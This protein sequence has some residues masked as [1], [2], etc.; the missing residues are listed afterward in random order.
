M[1]PEV[2]ARRH[3]KCLEIA[4]FEIACFEIAL[5]S[6]VMRVRII[7]R[8]GAGFLFF[9]W[10]VPGATLRFIGG[11]P[12][13]VRGTR[14]FARTPAVVHPD[15][16]FKVP[17]VLLVALSLF[18]FFTA[19]AGASPDN[20]SPPTLTLTEL[21]EKYSL[22]NS[23]YLQADGMDLHYVDEGS[24]SAIVLL[25]ASYQSLRT[26]DQLAER[27][28][29]NYRVVRVDFPNA[30]LSAD[31]KP[32]PPEK[33]NMMDRYQDAVGYLVDR[34]GI[35]RFTLVATS[36][37]G[38]AGFRYA[39]NH[40]DQVER[41]IL[42]NTAGMPR[43]PRTDPLRNRASVAKWLQMDVLPREFWD[44]S[45]SE[46]FIAPH[47]P[48]AWLVEQAFDFARLEGRSLRAKGYQYS[49]GDPKAILSEVRSPTLI[50]WGK[51]N[52]TVMHLEADVI[53]HWMT[54]AP[55]L[56]R[57]YEG[58][59]HYPYIED[60]DAIYGDFS[61]FVSGDLDPS[62]RRTTMVKPGANCA[63]E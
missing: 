15:R 29:P 30:G 32:V 28:R 33:F 25:H 37:G 31:N 10:V 41:L 55:T 61:A 63:C 62:L 36:S 42:I 60:L 38:A 27:L 16:R 17:R 8:S 14:V 54:A 9:R 49:T 39:R 47:E 21:R 24:G 44:F 19:M 22:P 48:P 12:V 34:L 46:N 23:R 53:Q 1:A 4:C 56:I 43:T 58:L 26:W 2:G 18:L 13:S 59:G 11:G 57:K 20:L 51:D 7:L 35:D 3:A 5:Q 45:L 50:M 6:L 40:P 52:P